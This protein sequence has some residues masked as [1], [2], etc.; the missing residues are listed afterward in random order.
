MKYVAAFHLM[1]DNRWLF[2]RKPDVCVGV[3][4]VS[5]GGNDAV[6][7]YMTAWRLALA[8][9]KSMMVNPFRTFH[10]VGRVEI[11]ALGSAEDDIMNLVPA[12]QTTA[13][14]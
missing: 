13:S 10:H 11:Y 2:K 1:G 14:R 4:Y 6:R 8:E 5:L 3:R 9:A 7:D 12:E